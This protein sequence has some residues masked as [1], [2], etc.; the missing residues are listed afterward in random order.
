MRLQCS[1]RRTEACRWMLRRQM[2][3]IA[4]IGVALIGI[5]GILL[6]LGL[7]HAIGSP[8]P[9]TNEYIAPD[10]HWIEV[11]S[12]FDELTVLHIGISVGNELTFLRSLVENVSRSN[13]CFALSALLSMLGALL[14]IIQNK[15]GIQHA[16]PEG[17]GEAPRP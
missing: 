3:S 13:E 11:P 5:A 17:R 9:F 16:P 8:R 6:A 4:K 10:G 2:K 15:R 12:T 14:I 7:Y 1:L